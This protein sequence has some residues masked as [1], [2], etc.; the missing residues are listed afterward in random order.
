MKMKQTMKRLLACTLAVVMLLTLPVTT[1]AQAAVKDNLPEKV[2]IY[3]STTPWSKSVYLT[4]EDT[5]KSIENV[6]SN[7][8]NLKAELVGSYTNIQQGNVYSHSFTIGMIPFKDGT[9]TVTYDIVKNDKVVDTRKMEVY[10]Y[11]SP[12]K[13][14]T[15]DG[16]TD[17]YYENKAKGKIKVS[18][19]SGNTIKKLEV[20]TYKMITDK[21][22]GQKRTDMTYKTFKNGDS[23]KLGTIGSYSEYGYGNRIKDESYSG[24]LN[25]TLKSYTEIKITYKDKY[26]KQEETISRAFYGLAK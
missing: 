6:K 26:T 1:K 9:Y 25:S 21:N 10:A 18:L 5:E 3:T 7:S 15:L 22:S 14:V 11:P 17:S 12:I 23:V 16:K 24:S 2:R 19:T 20:G 13:D 8:K 4:L